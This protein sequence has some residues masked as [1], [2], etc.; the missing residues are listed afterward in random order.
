MSVGVGTGV[1]ADLDSRVGVRVGVACLIARD[2]GCIV[3]VSAHAGGCR[4]GCTV[5][6]F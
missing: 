3:G 6:S 2:H 5:L 4:Y 1:R